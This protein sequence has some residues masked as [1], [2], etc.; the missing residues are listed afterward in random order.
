MKRTLVTLALL[1][2][3]T[4][5]HASQVANAWYFGHWSCVIDHRAAQMVWEVVDDPQTSCNGNICSSSSGVAVKGWF[6]DG[7][8]PWVKLINRSTSGTDLRFTYTGDS[9]RWFLRFD[10]NTQV[11][12]GNTMWRGNTYPLNCAKGK[13]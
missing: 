4:M 10:P 6:K 9:T 2:L 13:G 11:A 8:G 12:N 5:S 3:T 1:S 7:N